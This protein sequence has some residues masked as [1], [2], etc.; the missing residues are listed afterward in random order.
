M[1]KMVGVFYLLII[2][3]NPGHWG[4]GND[5]TVDNMWPK[6]SLHNSVTLI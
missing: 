2:R 6:V 5:I 4:L 3:A 1:C